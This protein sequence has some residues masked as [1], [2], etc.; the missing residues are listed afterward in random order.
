M[1]ISNLAEP[2][3]RPRNTALQKL[4]EDLERQIRPFRDIHK[5]LN[6]LSG[7]NHFKDIEAE[8]RRHAPDQRLLAM[9]KSIGGSSLI[10]QMMEQETATK[11]VQRLM[12]AYFPKTSAIGLFGSDTEAFKRAIGLSGSLTAK[13]LEDA[14]PKTS[15]YERLLEQMQHQALGGMSAVDYVRQLEQANPALSTIEAARKSF[16]NIFATFRDIDF[17]QMG[18]SEED[19]REAEAQVEDIAQMASEQ[20]DFQAATEQIA[21]AV[22]AHPNPFV[23]LFLWVHFRTL[24]NHIYGGVVSTV[25]SVAVTSCMTAV[26]AQSPQEATKNVKEAAKAA[27]SVP[28]LLADQRFISG[29]VVSVRM[30]PRANSPEL[31]RLKFGNVVRVVETE[32][33]FTLV[34]W[35][36]KDAGVE[37]KGWVFSRY[38]E[39]FK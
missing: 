38:L 2:P 37:I 16:D 39:K 32:R 8:I 6:Q 28:E 21:E 24:F 4:Q 11:Q 18:E 15:S 30:S 36:D 19:L 12:N 1:D 14:M 9:L 17:S 29:K 20:A 31:A 13:M 35:A 33:D 34:V 5:V 3:A 10:H 27:V 26:P 25:I 7:Y 22:A 23:R